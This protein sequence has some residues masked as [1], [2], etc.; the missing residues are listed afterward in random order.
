MR[1]ASFPKT[2]AP[3]FCSSKEDSH[4]SCLKP[5]NFHD[6]KAAYCANWS[7]AENP[8]SSTRIN[9]KSSLPQCCQPHRWLSQSPL[10]C[11]YNKK[12]EHTP[13]LTATLKTPLL[14]A[15]QRN[16]IFLHCK[17]IVFTQT[18]TKCLTI[19][20]ICTGLLNVHVNIRC[21]ETFLTPL[22][23]CVSLPWL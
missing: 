7:R 16:Q 1:E 2:Q 9:Q 11:L 6:Q 23:R 21:A 15:L 22:L 13:Y 8:T 14:N 19:F 17:N 4:V 18:F 20:Y 3:K 12:E 5:P 10:P